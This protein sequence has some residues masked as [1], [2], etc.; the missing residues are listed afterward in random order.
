MKRVIATCAAAGA[1][2]AA[3]VLPSAAAADLTKGGQACTQSKGN[4]AR[5]PGKNLLRGGQACL[6]SQG[7][8][9][10]CPGPPE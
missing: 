1:L 5:C 8:A 7:Q 4:A 10:R 2:G 6:H 3:A 9:A